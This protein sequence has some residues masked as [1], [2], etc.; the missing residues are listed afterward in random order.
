MFVESVEE[1]VCLRGMR[2]TAGRA[3]SVVD[4]DVDRRVG[5]Q[6]GDFFLQCR[7]VGHVR[8]E[9][10]VPLG[11]F[12]GQGVGHG[13]QCLRTTG[14]DGDAGA[15][16]RKLMCGRTADAVGSAADQGVLAGEIQIHL[17]DPVRGSFDCSAGLARLPCAPC[18]P[19]NA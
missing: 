17:D 10:A 11:V 13:L 9:P 3:A 15:K 7:A 18:A 16:Q 19:A 1:G 6:G 14:E 4:Q 5:G 2:R 12:P 8:R